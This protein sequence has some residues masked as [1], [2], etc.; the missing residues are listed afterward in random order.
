MSWAF[1]ILVAIIVGFILVKSTDLKHR[2][3]FFLIAGLAVFLG[4][5][6]GYVFLTNEFDLTSF[7]GWL[8]VGRVYMSGLGAFADNLAKV[9][10]F[11][12]RQDWAI[13]ITNSSLG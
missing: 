5:S 12:I 8:N 10:G 4:L 13:N 6:L 3:T 7:S 1:A 11:A 2:L 9:S